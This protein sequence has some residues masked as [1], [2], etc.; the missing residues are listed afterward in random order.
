MKQTKALHLRT[1]MFAAEMASFLLMEIRRTGKPV[2]SLDFESAFTSHP[3][4][5]L[6]NEQTGT[7][8]KGGSKDYFQHGVLK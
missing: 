1:S 6:Q 4:W 3:L 5:A 2:T 8:L 7:P